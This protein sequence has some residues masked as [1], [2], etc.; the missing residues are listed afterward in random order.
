MPKE[1]STETR[2]RT[3]F[4][5]QH[6]A[7]P[8]SKVAKTSAE[9]AQQGQA[10]RRQMK[11]IAPTLVKEADQRRKCSGRQSAGG[12]GFICYKASKSQ[13]SRGKAQQ[14]VDT[15]LSFGLPMDASS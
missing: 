2:G 5:D 15:S 1:A 11:V 7:R 14:H 10:H 4:I 9:D 6:L 8:I 12:T 13:P 3:R